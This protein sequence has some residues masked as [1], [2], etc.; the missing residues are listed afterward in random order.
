M[1]TTHD[2]LLSVTESN[3]MNWQQMANELIIQNQ[4]VKETMK[5]IKSKLQFIIDE[6]NKEKKDLKEQLAQVQMV[7]DELKKE[8]NQLR[9]DKD[10]QKNLIAQLQK[11]VQETE[12]IRKPKRNFC[13]DD[14]DSNKSLVKWKEVSKP[15]QDDSLQVRI[16]ELREIVERLLVT[17][18]IQ[19]AE[20]PTF[21][22]KP[23]ENV[24]NWLFLL[25]NR[26][27]AE[28]ISSSN[29]I[30][31][32]VGYLRDLALE[33]YINM[34]MNNNKKTTWNEVKEWFIEKFEPYNAQMKLRVELS[35]LK[36]KKGP[37]SYN[38]YVYKFKRLVNQA[39]N[40][41]DLDK[42]IYFKSGLHKYTSQRIQESCAKTLE[43][44]MHI[45]DSIE[46]F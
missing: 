27:D 42:I 5:E 36:Q 17:Q 6:N 12:S 38:T 4:M 46:N 39:F 13:M 30:Y 26:F 1:T 32:A 44:C 10:Q 29:R 11:K 3:K 21:S 16:N 23:N 24:R 34:S 15:I 31:I 41:N 14:L 8:L 43:E 28:H 37:N 40:M 33:T 18:T 35:K 19:E 2:K 45:A 25:E 7:N 20:I 9:T 22:G